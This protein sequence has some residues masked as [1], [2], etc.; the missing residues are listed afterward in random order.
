MSD[1]GLR[2][3]PSSN[4]VGPSG[5]RVSPSLEE[6]GHSSQNSQSLSQVSE[7]SSGKS[8][9]DLFME[10][11][12]IGPLSLADKQS[13]I[14]RT[15]HDP[16][17]HKQVLDQL[18]ELPPKL[19]RARQLRKYY[20]SIPKDVRDTVDPRGKDTRIYDEIQKIN[21]STE[22][23]SGKIPRQ[24]SALRSSGQAG[25]SQARQGA[26]IAPSQ[27]SSA[28]NA[29]QPHRRSFQ[30][31]AAG[32]SRCTSAERTDQADHGQA[33]EAFAAP[34]SDAAAAEAS[35]SSG[36]ELIKLV[37]TNKATEDQKK[38]FVCRYAC[39]MGYFGDLVCKIQDIYDK[40]PSS[41]CESAQLK[42]SKMLSLMYLTRFEATMTE[43]HTTL[44]SHVASRARQAGVGEVD[45]MTAALFTYLQTKETSPNQIDLVDAIADNTASTDQQHEFE[46]RL[47]NERPFA[48]KVEER[49]EIYYSLAR[50]DRSIQLRLTMFRL[51]YY[52]ELKWGPKE[53]L[54]LD[55]GDWQT[56]KDCGLAIQSRR[57]QTPKKQAVKP[58]RNS[59]G[60][61]D[62]AGKSAAGGARSNA[63][64]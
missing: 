59:Q 61:G 64:V 19:K 27:V 23:P 34:L 57:G 18:K 37:A 63:A 52:T 12:V 35:R 39:E 29:S 44:I 33:P 4:V 62:Q 41:M 28:L 9:L 11:M 1:R 36:I 25:Q 31:N 10:A 16:I 43:R 3:G 49:L 8:D 45:S 58:D 40:R 5:R 38:M 20:E 42:L 32:S 55:H 56:A 47:K 53:V 22:A 6:G 46:S 50:Y 48:Q 30:S 21:L 13:F 15:L 2:G 17:F 51:S 54:L 14:D 26:A 7:P 60:R 24:R